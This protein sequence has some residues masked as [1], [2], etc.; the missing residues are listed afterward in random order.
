MGVVNDP[1]GDML[2]RIRNAVMARH[3]NVKI[4]VSKIKVEIAKI[5]HAEGYI[6]GYQL[7]AKGREMRLRL[8]YD[9]NNEPVIQGIKR[10]S[11]PGRRVY[12]GRKEL[13]RVLSGLGIA[14]LSTDQGV[15]TAREARR[16]GIGGEVLAYVW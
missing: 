16:R 3:P 5:L 14:I 10:V 6:R 13:P 2:T 1:I 8:K 9:D 11:K 12:V 4:P 15:M 7:V